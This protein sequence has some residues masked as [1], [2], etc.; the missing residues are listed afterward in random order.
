MRS[1]SETMWRKFQDDYAPS[2]GGGAGG[3]GWPFGRQSAR[4][5]PGRRARARLIDCGRW[6][7]PTTSATESRLLERQGWPS[8]GP[9]VS[10][11]CRSARAG[12][13]PS[14]RALDS[15]WVKDPG[16]SATGRR[17]TPW[18]ARGCAGRSLKIR[19]RGALSSP[20]SAPD[21]LPDSWPC[22]SL[23]E[24]RQVTGRIVASGS[25]GP[26]FPARKRTLGAHDAALRALRAPQHRGRVRGRA[27]GDVQDFSR[28]AGR[29]IT[30]MIRVRRS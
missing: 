25:S 10:S 17:Y 11:S 19:A 4:A 9:W 2:S 6:R 3:R 24:A 5:G 15:A 1:W 22:R 28:L 20:A 26:N 29:A 12:G 13:Q 27:L 14:R 21:F 8:G 23:R 16:S 7:R 30:R 18:T